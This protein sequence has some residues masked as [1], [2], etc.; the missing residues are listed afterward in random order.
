V[1]FVGNAA[2]AGGGGVSARYASVSIAGGSFQQNTDGA[3]L[4]GPGTSAYLSGGTT[5]SGNA[6]Q[7]TV[8]SDSSFLGLD[9][10]ILLSPADLANCSVQ[11]ASAMTLSV[12]PGSLGGVQ[13]YPL[14][15]VNA[16]A[17]AL[18]VS[19]YCALIFDS[20]V[21]IDGST[22]Q[23]IESTRITSAGITWTAYQTLEPYGIMIQYDAFGT[24][25]AFMRVVHQFFQRNGTV[26]TPDNVTT[27]IPEGTL[28]VT[29]ELAVW[30]WSSPGNSLALILAARSN[31][32]I[33]QVDQPSPTTFVLL[34]PQLTFYFETPLT[35]FYDPAQAL[36]AVEV[37][38]LGM[39]QG[40]VRFQFLFGHFQRFVSYDPELTVLLGGAGTD[41]S[42]SGPD[43]G[44][45][46]G[47]T[48]GLIGGAVVV[49][50]VMIVALVAG[51]WGL[52]YH[53]SYLLGKRLSPSVHVSSADMVV[54]ES[55]EL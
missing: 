38:A 43:V 26:T 31:D 25:G 44:L 54:P 55:E 28:K 2:V 39:Q 6:P 37:S 22:Q 15:A 8:C 7:D 32:P 24:N 33:V 3:I 17:I 52:G 20:V 46:V 5:F 48:V 23:P 49:V 14:S 16:T 13:L 53:R 27:E 4:V 21:E 41:G 34:T 36:G 18:L 19:P 10:T 9:E 35:A 30:P 42:S 47:L 29:V 12:F 45:I 50:V 11:V 40:G 51:G 1:N